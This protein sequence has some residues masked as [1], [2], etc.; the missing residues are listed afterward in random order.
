M[1]LVDYKLELI[2]W[3]KHS[4]RPCR[5]ARINV[6]KRLIKRHGGEAVIRHL[7]WIKKIL[8]ETEGGKR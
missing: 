8:D 5:M 4:R 6:Y 2:E 1:I 7:D 3:K